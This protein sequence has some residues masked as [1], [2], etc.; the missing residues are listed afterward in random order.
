[1][2]DE[3]VRRVLIAVEAASRCPPRRDDRGG[4]VDQ[5][6]RGRVSADA[7]SEIVLRARL[8]LYRRRPGIYPKATLHEALNLSNAAPLMCTANPSGRR[9]I[10]CLNDIA[11]A[12]LR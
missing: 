12:F 10:E 7:Y 3:V 8:K 2:D 9:T 5:K 1:M 11:D 6:Q 4:L